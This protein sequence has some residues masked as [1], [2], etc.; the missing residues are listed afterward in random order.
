MKKIVKK[1]L[2]NVGGVF[3]TNPNIIFNNIEV[4]KRYGVELDSENGYT[5]LG[6]SDLE[7]RINELINNGLWNKDMM[8]KSLE[9]L[10]DLII[11]NNY[12]TCKNRNSYGRIE[13]T[14]SDEEKRIKMMR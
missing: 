14:S 11:K 5:I 8:G 1:V 2:E 7:D 13:T 4:L 6:M 12:I 10:K 9:S 3:T